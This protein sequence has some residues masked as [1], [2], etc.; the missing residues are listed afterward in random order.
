MSPN[1]PLEKIF[2][3]ILAKI[4]GSFPEPKEQS[5]YCKLIIKFSLCLFPNNV[6]SSINLYT[7]VPSSDVDM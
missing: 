5:M 7:T 4:N 6:S 1:I 2:P 3:S